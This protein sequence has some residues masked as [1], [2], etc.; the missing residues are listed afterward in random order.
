VVLFFSISNFFINK[1]SQGGKL[2]AKKIPTCCNLALSKY[3]SEM[4]DFNYDADFGPPSYWYL[5]RLLHFYS[6]WLWAYCVSMLERVLLKLRHQHCRDDGRWI[7]WR[8]RNGIL[9][10]ILFWPTEKKKYSS[11]W[12]TFEIW[13]WR[14]RICINFEITFLVTYR[15][16]FW[17]VSGGFSYLMI[18]SNSNS[19][20]K[21]GLGFRI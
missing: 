5:S 17:F 8:N 13:G 14:L 6:D 12:E 21:K 11:D 15:I 1:K 20:C 19:N 9:L 16:L 10:P 7:S 4:G 2:N 18:L 3:G